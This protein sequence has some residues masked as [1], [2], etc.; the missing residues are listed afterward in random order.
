M[1]HEVRHTQRI[2]SN[3]DQGRRRM[4]DG[5]QHSIR[6]VRIPSHAVWTHQRTCNMASLHQ[7]RVTSLPR[8]IR[9]RLPRRHFG[10]LNHQRRTHTARTTNPRRVTESETQDQTRENG[11][12]QTGNGI[13]RVYRLGLRTQDEP[14]QSHRHQG[15]ASTQICQGNSVF[16]W[17]CELLSKVHTGLLTNS[18]TAYRSHQKESGIPVD[19]R[20]AGSIRRL[21]ETV[22]GR[23]SAGYVRPNE[24]NHTRNRCIRQS[25]RSMPVTEGRQRKVTPYCLLLTKIHTYGNELP[26]SRQGTCRNC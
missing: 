21:E 23:T 3:S 1:V 20:D 17:I 11:I 25:H 5:F 7:Q 6:F 15:M 26:R 10:L 24:G 14:R 4:E 9:H 22:R 19:H 2:W 16:P 12:S 18:S 13:P 8:R